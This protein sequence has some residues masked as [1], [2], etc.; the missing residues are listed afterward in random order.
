MLWWSLQMLKSKN[1]LK[2]REAVEKLASLEDGRLAGT[3]HAMI[4]DTNPEVRTAAV[5]GLAA[6]RSPSLLQPLLNAL[7][8]TEPTVREAAVAGIGALDDPQTTLFLV[9]ALKDPAATVRQKA[10]KTLHNRKW[11]PQTD[12]ERALRAVARGDFQKAAAMGAVGLEPLSTVL[13]SEDPFER[14]AAVEALAR[15]GD[16]RA[17]KPLLAALSDPASHV[18]NAAVEALARTGDSR[19]L[20][21][22]MPALK[23]EDRHVRATAAEAL[24]RLGGVGAV[25]PLQ[26]ALRDDWWDVRAS[27]AEALGRIGDSRAVSALVSTLSDPD[28][29]VRRCAVEALGRLGQPGV[30]EPLVLM[31]KDEHASVRAVVPAVLLR[32]DPGWERSEAARR[33]LPKLKAALGHSEYWVRQAAA[34]AI[35]RITEVEPIQP[36]LGGLA[37]P[38]DYSRRAATETFLEIL[39]DEDRDF[40]QAAVEALGRIGDQRVMEALVQSMQDPDQGV[41]IAAARALDS[42]RWKP[43]EDWQGAMHQRLMKGADA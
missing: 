38:E 14:Q 10:A 27:A 22:V 26:N 42:L 17:V 21:S 33:A 7:S 15:L 41:C 25:D 31:L 5:K 8:D 18:R 19:M 40:R 29:D 20:E 16:A 12:T 6:L 13:R 35:R 4:A 37:A 1:A 9:E 3:L 34:Q 43:A 23:D 24:G 36:V 11:E 28:H 39:A 32:V 2:R 30:I